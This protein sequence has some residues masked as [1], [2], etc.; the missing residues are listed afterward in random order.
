MSIFTARKTEIK[1][2]EEKKEEVPPPK[3]EEAPKPV[4]P[5]LPAMTLEPPTLPDF[6]GLGE[7]K[8]DIDMQ[9]SESEDEE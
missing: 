1:P 7:P 2:V 5:L 8:H 4:E 3:K 6:I 9:E